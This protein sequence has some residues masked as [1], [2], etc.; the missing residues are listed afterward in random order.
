M[1]KEESRTKTKA[2]SVFTSLAF[3]SLWMAFAFPLAAA[4]SLC[5]SS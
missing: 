5:F 1:A 3:G 2:S 4:A